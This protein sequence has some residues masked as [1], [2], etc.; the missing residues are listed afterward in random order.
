MDVNYPWSGQDKCYDV[1]GEIVPCSGS[2]QDGEHRPGR[3]WPT[4][5]F[6]FR[7]DALVRDRLTGLFWPQSANLAGWPMS[8]VEARAFVSRCNQEGLLGRDDWRLPLRRELLS[9]LSLAHSRPALP[10]GHPFVHIF[11]HWYWTGSAS[12]VS[13]DHF[14]RVHLEGGRM[15]SGP[16]DAE[17]LVWPVSGTTWLLPEKY[18][19]CLPLQPCPQTRFQESD[20]EILDNLSGLVWLKHALPENGDTNWSDALEAARE[21]GAPW[22]LPSIWE[23]ESLVDV[24]RAWPALPP[25]HPFLG[26]GPANDQGNAAS[27]DKAASTGLWSSTSSGYDPAWAWVLYVG[28]GAVGVGHK[29]GRH[30]KF[31]L[32]RGRA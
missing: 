29:P 4:P 28:K 22:R 10:P 32:T 2:G 19:D 15:F 7:G 12:A 5:R 3:N 27:S 9:L 8:H 20:G 25:G 6:E 17:H 30:F 14:W 16:H 31:L 26:L 24:S 13:H 21:L 18:E 11:Q 1:Y 23:L